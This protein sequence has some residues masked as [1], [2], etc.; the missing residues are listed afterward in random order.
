MSPRVSVF[1]TVQTWEA[2]PQRVRGMRVSGRGD[3]RVLS[4]HVPAGV[5][6]MDPWLQSS[7]EQGYRLVNHCF[8]VVTE[9][10]G[11]GKKLWVSKKES[12]D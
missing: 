6:K 2:R 11:V 1:E 4:G 8:V 9:A 3:S 7:L 5:C 10:V 12:L